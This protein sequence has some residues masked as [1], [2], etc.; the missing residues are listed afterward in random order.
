METCS[1]PDRD[2][3][4]ES[5]QFAL[6]FVSHE[7][8][9][10]GCGYGCLSGSMEECKEL[11]HPTR[12]LLRVLIEAIEKIHLIGCNPPP[13]PIDRSKP[14][15]FLFKKPFWIPFSMQISLW[16]TGAITEQAMG[17]AI[18]ELTICWGRWT[19]KHWASGEGHPAQ[20]LQAQHRKEDFLRLEI[21]SQR[22]KSEEGA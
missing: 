17:T 12:D 8:N 18:K 19:R 13:P 22:G 14:F 7:L 5:D 21:R 20:S 11:T 10:R 3:F 9:F 4:R 1:G 2:L 16:G 15:V 6:L